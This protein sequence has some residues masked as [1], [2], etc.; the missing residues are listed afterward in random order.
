MSTLHHVT[1]ETFQRDV[2]ESSTPVL[3]DFWAAW[4]PP[5]RMLE[6]ILEQVSQEYG[7]KLK[8][9]KLNVDENP[10]TAARY[11]VRNIPMLNVHVNG[12]VAK[13]IVGAKPKRVLV[14]ELRAFLTAD[15]A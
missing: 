10:T 2:L 4:C 7:D 3:V 11:G 13:T 12:E 15:A 6:P 9:V 14:E 8:I 5:C 1:D